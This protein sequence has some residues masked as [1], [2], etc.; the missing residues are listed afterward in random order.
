MKNASKMLTDFA[1][2]AKSYKDQEDKANKIISETTK[3][4]VAKKGR[5]RQEKDIEKLT[6]YIPKEISRELDTA[7]IE[8]RGDLKYL[9]K[10][11]V[12]RSTIV[13]IALEYALKTHKE[14][15][16]KSYIKESLEKLGAE[17]EASAEKKKI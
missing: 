11:L 7:W 13:A 1:K 5:P 14:K 8:L 3:K 9:P 4:K 12:S 16:R 15:G 10:S 6:V 17:A 2:E